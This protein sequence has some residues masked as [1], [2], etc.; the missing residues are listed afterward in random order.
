M[1]F[2]TQVNCNP[3]ILYHLLMSLCN[4]APDMWLRHHGDANGSSL[5]D[6]AFA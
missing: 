2:M 3:Y 6:D 5:R 4:K 1:A